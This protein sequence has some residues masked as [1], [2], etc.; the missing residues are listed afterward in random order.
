MRWF[1]FIFGDVGNPSNKMPILYG[2]RHNEKEL[3]LRKME[4][5]LPDKTVEVG[6]AYFDRLSKKQIGFVLDLLAPEQR[7]WACDL[8]REEIKIGRTTIHNYLP[9]Q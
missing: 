2:F 5:H 6:N 9:C 8:N 1:L 4:Q 3:Y 7:A